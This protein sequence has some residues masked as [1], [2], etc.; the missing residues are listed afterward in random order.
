MLSYNTSVE[1]GIINV[2]PHVGREESDRSSSEVAQL[3]S[4]YDHLCHGIGELR[5]KM[6]RLHIDSSV[7]P[8]TQTHRRVPF[9]LRDP[10][11]RELAEL[12]KLDIIE[13]VEGIATPWV[14]PVVVAPKPKKPSVPG[15]SVY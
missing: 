4:T 1:L 5:G 2:I 13:P 8:V 7:T 15:T 12:E 9:H 10:V 11:A 3:V 14:S 6:I